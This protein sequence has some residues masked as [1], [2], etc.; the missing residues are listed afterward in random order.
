VLKLI[1]GCCIGGFRRIM[2]SRVTM[3]E[4]YERGLD[5]EIE[6]YKNPE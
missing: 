4:I 6:R 1:H 2:D 5:Y 3:L